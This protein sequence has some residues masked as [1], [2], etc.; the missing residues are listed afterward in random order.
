LQ[1]EENLRKSNLQSIIKRLIDHGMIKN[2]KVRPSTARDF[3]RTGFISE[4]AVFE[5]DATA[6]PTATNVK[7]NASTQ[8]QVD[9]EPSIQ[10][11]KN[12]E[13]NLFI[14]YFYLGD[15][16][17]VVLDCLYQEGNA[18]INEKYVSGAENFK[19]ILSSF[20]YKHTFG[21]KQEPTSLN[22]AHIPISVELF[23]EWFAE[24]IIKPE[25]K[26]YP[27]MYFIRDIAKFLVSEILLETCFRN[28]LEKSLQFKTTNFL[29]AKTRGKSDPIGR[30]LSTS[31]KRV[32]DLEAEYK[33]GFLPLRSD[34]T[35]AGSDI[36]KLY[37]YVVIYVDLPK[38]DTNKAGIKSDDGKQGIFHYQLGRPRGILKKIKFS[39]SDMQ[40]VRE[41]RFFRHGHDGLMQLSS[42]YKVSLDMVGNTLY[43]PGM[44][45][46]IDPRGLLGAGSEFDPTIGFKDGTPSIANK[47]GFGGYHIVTRVNSSIGPGKFTTSVDALFSYSGDGDP[48]SKLVGRKQATSNSSIASRDF[49]R[50]SAPGT[51]NTECTA[52][53]NDLYQDSLRSIYGD[54]SNI[55]IDPDEG[56]N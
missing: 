5:S 21:E 12:R 51:K 18:N 29:A 14:N 22:L 38:V 34:L 17:F 20:Q 50:V 35:G 49:P 44:E 32:L 54:A 7:E 45:I 26:S 43:Y 15:L 25:R 37:N 28:E 11:L 16:L 53:I 10:S 47:L 33:S 2:V 8:E 41:A 55:T 42:V 1:I 39:K 13:D 30:K 31:G 9:E 24:N 36:S 56:E 23:N 40:Y 52:K 19:F 48:L 4:P 27:V 6:P 46:F 3:E